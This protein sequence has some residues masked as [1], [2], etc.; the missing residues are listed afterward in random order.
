MQYMSDG[1]FFFFFGWNDGNNSEKG[2]RNK[3]RKDQDVVLVAQFN[4]R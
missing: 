3:L 1:I 2:I 4:T